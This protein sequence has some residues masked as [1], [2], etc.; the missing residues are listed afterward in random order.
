MR[1]P[2]DLPDLRAAAFDLEE[3]PPALVLAAWIADAEAYIATHQEA[4]D[5]AFKARRRTR[6]P[7]RIAGM[8]WLVHLD[9]MI[10]SVAGNGL[11]R[12]FLEEAEDLANSVVEELA[13]KLFWQDG[14]PPA[15]VLAADQGGGGFQA[16]H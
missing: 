10:K 8:H 1:W 13:V 12:Y 7:E 14:R 3:Q 16:Y 2:E 6:R 4:E 9:A 15:L 5:A 11:V